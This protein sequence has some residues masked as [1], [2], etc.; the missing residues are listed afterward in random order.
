M[1]FVLTAFIFLHVHPWCVLLS[2]MQQEFANR[3]AV[4][5]SDYLQQLVAL[6]HTH[7]LAKN[8]SLQVAV[9]L[10]LVSRLCSSQ[11]SPLC[12]AFLYL[13]SSLCSLGRGVCRPSFISSFLSQFYTWEVFNV[14]ASR[15]YRSGSYSNCTW[16]PCLWKTSRDCVIMFEF[17][18]GCGPS[19]H[20][21][22]GP[23]FTT[24]R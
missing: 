22:F 24:I 3:L 4:L 18:S 12:K 14:H 7:S 8:S 19:G 9:I 10:S 15:V 6:L 20:L 5:S 23:H 2:F 13:S 17:L 16:L 11:N 1:R 21:D